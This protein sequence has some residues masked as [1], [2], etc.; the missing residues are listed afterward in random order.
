MLAEL[1]SSPRLC[2]QQEGKRFMNGPAQPPVAKWT[3]PVS[4]TSVLQTLGVVL[5]SIG[6]F[7][8]IASLVFFGGAGFA[9][10]IIGDLAV[11]GKTN[12]VLR[13]ETTRVESLSFEEIS[14]LAGYGDR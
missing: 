10:L 3:N 7:G 1:V 5:I 6:F 13:N 12:V 9:L 4:S 2:H 14:L 8:N 11:S